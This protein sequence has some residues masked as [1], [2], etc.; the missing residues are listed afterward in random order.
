[1]LS[2]NSLTRAE[3]LELAHALWQELEQDAMPLDTSPWHGAALDEAQ[4]AQVYRH[5]PL[6]RR[7]TDRSR[8]S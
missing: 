8:Q 7:A 1:M 2:I 6:R 5:L 3:K 4:Q